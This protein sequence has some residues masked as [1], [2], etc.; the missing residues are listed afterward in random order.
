MKVPFFRP[1]VSDHLASRVNG[2]VSRFDLS[3]GRG[4]AFHE[5]K[6]KLR[7]MYKYDYCILT[8]SGTSACRAAVAASVSKHP[9]RKFIGVP[10][11]S[12]SADVMPVVEFDKTPVFSKTDAYGNPDFLPALTHTA[13]HLS[14]A[15]LMCPYVY[16]EMPS[17]MEVYQHFGWNTD[18]VIIADISQAVGIGKEHVFGDIALGSLRTEKFVGCGEGGFLMTNDKFLYEKALQFCT[19]GKISEHLP[20]TCTRYGDNLLMPGLTAAAAVSQFYMLHDVIEDKSRV[21]KMYLSSDVFRSRGVFIESECGMGW[22]TMW[23]NNS[24]LASDV[25]QVMRENGIECRPGFYPLYLSYLQQKETTLQFDFYTLDA[26]A[27]TLWKH[28]V[29]LPTP[30]GLTREEFSAIENVVREN[31]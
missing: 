20:Y 26:T 18:A 10:Q 12:C 7:N 1:C 2:V 8:N 5:L 11:Y 24:V 29:V 21:R 27:D 17:Q 16:G 14:F 13:N 9:D 15:A 31:F 22:Q 3:G 28:G 4:E 23:I 25:I 19:R 30:Y 6:D